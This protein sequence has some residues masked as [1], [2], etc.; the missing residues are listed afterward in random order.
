MPIMDGGT[1]ASC[2]RQHEKRKRPGHRIP[3]FAVSASLVEHRKKEYCKLGFD[4]WIL[5]P[6]DFRRL[7]MLLEG[8]R[9]ET[10]RREAR[11]IP[12]NWES[13]GWFH[14]SPAEAQ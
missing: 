8:S 10:V 13:G 5:K 3:I 4:G 6:V 11:Y 1:S 9:N 12:G 14:S 7:A 2:I